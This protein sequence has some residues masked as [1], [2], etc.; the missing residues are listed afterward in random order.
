MSSS[1]SEA[2]PPKISSEK[3]ESTFLV[4]VKKGESNAKVLFLDNQKS[5]GWEGPFGMS[6]TMEGMVDFSA[7]PAPRAHTWPASVK[8]SESSSGEEESGGSETSEK[9]KDPLYEKKDWTNI[10]KETEVLGT[11]SSWQAQ[12]RLVPDTATS[13]RRR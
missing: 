5:Q 7:R 10:W 13:C 6:M 2:V 9:V 8:E 4:R 3:E 11:G 12:A 1:S